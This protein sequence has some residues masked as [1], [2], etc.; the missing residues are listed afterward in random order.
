VITDVNRPLNF[1]IK[2]LK[3]RPDVLIIASGEITLPGEPEVKDIGLPPGV[4]YASMA[5]AIVLAL[6]GRFE[7]FSVG[8]DIK[9]EKVSEIYKMGLKHGMR[10]ASITGIEGVLT[11]KDFERVRALALRARETGRQ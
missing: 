4:A 11:D 7:N 9:W 8:R 3:K 2:D 5:E 1:T 6:E 10:L